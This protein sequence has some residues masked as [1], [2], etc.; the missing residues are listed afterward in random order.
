M[1]ILFS[2]FLLMSFFTKEIYALSPEP[3]W[4]FGIHDPGQ[5]NSVPGETVNPTAVNMFEQS[6]KKC[7]V[8]WTVQIGQDPNNHSGQDFTSVTSR[9]HGCIVRLN[10][11]HESLGCI[12]N[13]T[14][15]Y[16]AFAQRCANFVA[17]STGADK[18][19]IGNEMNLGGTLPLANY[20]NCYMQVR[21]AIKSVPG[22]SNDEIINGA[23]AIGDITYAE[24][25]FK[26]L[27]GNIDGI[28]IHTYTNGH[29]CD[30]V[31]R[32]E[33]FGEYKYVMAKIPASMRN[34]PVYITECG[35]GWAG[36]YPSNIETCYVNSI[37]NEINN[38][39]LN[40][41]NQKIRAVCFYRWCCDLWRIDNKSY[42]ISQFVTSAQN[43]YRW[44]LDYTPTPIP[45]ATSSPTPPFAIGDVNGDGFITPGDA[46][47][48]FQ[49]Y[50]EILLDP[51]CFVCAD[52]DGNG[53]VTPGDALC[54]FRL[55]LDSPC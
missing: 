7:W 48:A 41:S 6:G 36:A 11:T 17:A 21:N 1:T 40:S 33:G 24:N 43:D 44:R 2:C 3:P 29:G 54:I 38:W 25:L 34:L 19:L 14:A 52:Y 39:N 45:T 42:M 8:L 46:L 51:V 49:I 22:H 35:S 23:P 32:P 26:S 31:Y 30:G 10:L 53:R 27:E 15:D 13:S 5:Y 18:W 50:M 20:V 55:Y 37:F 9:G 4:I 12:P 47:M 28:A 16:P